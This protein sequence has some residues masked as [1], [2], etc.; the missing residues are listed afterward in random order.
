MGSMERPG[1]TNQF[2]YREDGEHCGINKPSNYDEEQKLG[3][4]EIP[5]YQVLEDLSAQLEI[6]SD[7]HNKQE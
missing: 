4:S 3:P 5:S 1:L 6:I 7:M 2:G